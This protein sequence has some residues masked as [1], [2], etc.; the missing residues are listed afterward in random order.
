MKK[1]LLATAVLFV[2]L[3]CTKD[4]FKIDEK[5]IEDYLAE[6]GLEATQHKSGIWHNISDPGEGVRPDLT[7]YIKVRYKGYT[8]DNV[9]FDQTEEGDTLTFKLSQFIVGW[10]IAVPMLKQG[11]KGVFYFPSELGYGEAVVGS[12][13]ANSVLIFEIELIDSWH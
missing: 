13:P 11:G 5:I 10:Q 4:Q 12:I 6:K 8:T 2:V 9:V 1:F 3:S 7:S